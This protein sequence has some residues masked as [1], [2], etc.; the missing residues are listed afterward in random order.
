MSV[1]VVGLSH[2]TAPIELLERTTLAPDVASELAVELCR[3]DHVIEAVSL[4]TC[5]RLEVY[6]EVSKFHGGVGEIGTA[7]A[8]VTGVSLEELTE[9]LYVHYEGAAV[10]HLFRVTCGLESMAVG[11]AQILGQVRTA[12]RAAQSSGSA[13]RTIGHLIQNALRVGKRAH[14][15]TRLDRAGPTLVEAGLKRA[16]ELLGSLQ[17]ARVLV[18]GAGAMS[19]LAVAS[20]YRAG[21]ASI[22]VSS[23]TPGRAG[24][25]AA[26][27]DGTPVPLEGLP[28]ALAGADLV[29][30]CTGSTGYLVSELDV[31]SARAQRSAGVGP[32]A[33]VFVDLALPRDVEP[34]V[35]RLPGVSVFDLEQ[36]GRDLTALGLSEDLADVRSL[37]S[38]E[39]AIYLADQRAKEVAP[40]VVA[41]RAMAR[42][43]VE[44]ELHRL[45]GR[46][47]TVDAALLGELEQT[48][49][50][51][52]EKLLHM[53]TVRVK[54]LAAEPGG[55]SYAQALRLLFDLGPEPVDTV[56][57]LPADLPAGVELS[58]QLTPELGVTYNRISQ[59]DENDRNGAKDGGRGVATSA[60]PIESAAPG[61]I[62]DRL[63]RLPGRL[64]LGTRRSALARTQSQWVADRLGSALAQYGRRAE[65]DLVDVTTHGDLNRAPL[66]SLGGTGVFVSA[67]RDALLART[68]DFAV[69]SLKDLPTGPADG[70]VLAALP[71]REDPRDVLIAR[72][73]LTLS[74]LPAGA[75]V[76]TGSPR[77]A[78][79]LRAL[80][81]G[82]EV[83]DVRGNVDTRLRLVSDG[84]LD[85]IVLARAG[86][87]RLGRAAEAT[88]VFDPLLML[89]APGQGALA[90]EARV[91]DLPLLSA[92]GL[93]DDP[94]TRACVLAERSLLARLEA[95]CSAPVGALCEVVEGEDGLE[96][97]LRAVVGSLDGAVSMRRSATVQLTGLVD[98]PAPPDWP[99]PTQALT[100]ADEAAATALGRGLAEQMLDDGA[101]ELIPVRIPLV[102][103]GTAAMAREGDS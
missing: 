42:S 36:L 31:R 75:T 35:A 92:L 12:L 78:A 72:D 22:A 89:P 81:L 93:L 38:D 64:R 54:E 16:A 82:L 40:T 34:T 57:G 19:G 74:Q 48:V 23:R 71:L 7:L 99:A 96:L 60:V 103:A 90:V 47:G 5:N 59:I 14:T 79:Q 44:T 84:V 37:V 100:S 20:A 13:G 53:P 30:A 21:V 3:G 18:L 8:K 24:R 39:V 66:S 45:E 76:G 49:H 62:Q 52:V 41:L 27:V 98:S 29:I 28:S 63:S 55:D 4:V 94:A 32:A 11:E 2:R 17:S 15:E 91:E 43:V 87:V 50:R 70:L 56:A 65:V 26:S 58:V 95:G 73:G 33:Q 69:H 86:L 67:L 97:S 25:L 46:I 51:V 77:R 83:V 10:A 61:L 68:I 80:G 102:T 88:E 101:A 1:L 6:A 9:H 85:A